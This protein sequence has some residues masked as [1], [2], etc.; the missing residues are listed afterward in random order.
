M[1]DGKLEIKISLKET[2]NNLAE[3]AG[4]KDKMFYEEAT[5]TY[6]V[7]SVTEETLKSE[8]FKFF[9]YSFNKT[10]IYKKEDVYACY[11][12][13]PAFGNIMVYKLYNNK[14]RNKEE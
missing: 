2:A 7:D 1:V 9:E 10:P 5:K 6:F 14:L 13:D 8:G 12:S 11:N 4:T 3:A